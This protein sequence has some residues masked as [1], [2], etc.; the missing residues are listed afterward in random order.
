MRCFAAWPGF[1]PRCLP[2]SPP[3]IEAFETHDRALVGVLGDITGGPPLSLLQTRQAHL[4]TAKGGLGLPSLAAQAPLSY[5]AAWAQV[6]PALGSTLAVAGKAAIPGALAFT[7]P[8]DPPFPFQVALLAARASLPPIVQAKLP[9]P[10]ELGVR[11]SGLRGLDAP[12][13][14]SPL[15]AA[16]AALHAHDLESLLHEMPSAEDKARFLSTAGTAA[17]AWLNAV[18]I[19]PST[20]I[21]NSLFRTALRLRLGATH[22]HLTTRERCECGVAWGSAPAIHALR[23]AT[24]GGPTAVHNAVRD[25]VATL[26]REAGL[27]TTVEPVGLLPIRP[28]D[29]LGRRPDLACSDPTGGSRSLLDITIVDPL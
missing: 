26:A 18:P 13:S 28:G 14:L 24:D 11:G 15:S 7:S 25:C 16:S 20:T 8:P 12:P 10:S 4:P 3:L 27:A 6:A 1:L 9:L 22:P 2:P 29:T 21:P 23:C 5:V 19:H 17:G